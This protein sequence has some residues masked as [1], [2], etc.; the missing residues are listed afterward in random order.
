MATFDRRI[1]EAARA[2]DLRVVEP[3][4]AGLAPINFP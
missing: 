4:I 3:P 2:L 1:L